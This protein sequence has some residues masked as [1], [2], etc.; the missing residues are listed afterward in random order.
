ML[1]VFAACLDRILNFPYSNGHV[2]RVDAF[3]NQDGRSFALQ[4]PGYKDIKLA[5]TFKDNACVFRGYISAGFFLFPGFFLV[6]GSF[7]VFGL[8]LFPGL[9]LVFVCVLVS[10]SLL[11][12]GCFLVSGS[13]LDLDRLLGSNSFLVSGSFPISGQCF[14]PVIG[15]STITGGFCFFRLIRQFRAIRVQF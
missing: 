3:I 15:L 13:L 2:I 11:V 10:A 14:D 6:L 9:F 7:L 5:C 12:L 4:C 8:F 1:F